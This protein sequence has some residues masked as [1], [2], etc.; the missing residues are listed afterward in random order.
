MTSLQRAERPLPTFAGV[1]FEAERIRFLFADGGEF[2]APLSWYPRLARATAAQRAN[3]E[4]IGDGDGVHWPD[5]DED[6][7]A[8]GV[9]RGEPDHTLREHQADWVSPLLSR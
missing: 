4:L 5:V 2:T 1:R 3:W 7:S 9:L 8:E 6:L